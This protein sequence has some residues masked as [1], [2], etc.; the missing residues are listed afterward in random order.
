ML[1]HICAEIDCRMVFFLAKTS[2]KLQ[3]NSTHHGES[4]SLFCDVIK[5]CVESLTK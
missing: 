2:F 1:D 3:K 4:G 5:T